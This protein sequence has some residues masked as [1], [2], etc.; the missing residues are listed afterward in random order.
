VKPSP[1]VALALALFAPAAA[2][3]GEPAVP[4]EALAL[5]PEPI[6]AE[7]R[8]RAAEVEAMSREVVA[9][10]DAL[11]RQASV[12]AAAAARRDLRAAL[13]AARSVGDSARAQLQAARLAPVE[14][15]ITLDLARLAER[16]ARDDLRAARGGHGRKLVRDA[17]ARL[18]EAR[19]TR[20]DASWALADATF[21]S[22]RTGRAAGHE[23][24]VADD[25]V[26]LARR[27]LNEVG[28]VVRGAGRQRVT[29]GQI[30]VLEAQR[31]VALAQL[32]YDRA[33]VAIASGAR[34]RIKPYLQALDAAR[35][36]ERLAREGLFAETY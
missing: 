11:A 20:I 30:A 34:M 36:A 27:A 6:R 14:A 31:D 5:V 13:D 19:E 1:T 12:D 2:L 10:K 8:A 29:P 25:A 17:R 35:Q 33:R 23:V 9:A 15:R 7:W 18:D 26:A 21:D 4:Q 16:R 24:A 28:P 22:A 3:G 32:E